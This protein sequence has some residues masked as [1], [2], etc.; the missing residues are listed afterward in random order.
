M[1]T[2]HRIEYFKEM[3]KHWLD[4]YLLEDY[5]PNIEFW[6]MKDIFE[7]IYTRGYK[8]AFDDYERQNIVDDKVIK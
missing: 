1:N 8:Q 4:I 3:R 2:D 6:T 7:F 5:R